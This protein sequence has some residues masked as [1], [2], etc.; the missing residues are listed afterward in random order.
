LL[1]WRPPARARR[2]AVERGVVTRKTANGPVLLVAATPPERVRRRR[3]RCWQ[4][5]EAVAVRNAFI[6]TVRFAFTKA[7]TAYICCRKMAQN[8]Q[9]I[10]HE[11][12]MRVCA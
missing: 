5:S 7:V 2:R 9:R 12:T 3:R 10:R 6:A 11:L 1:Q 8:L 4:I